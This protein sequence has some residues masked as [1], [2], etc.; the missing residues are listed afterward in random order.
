MSSQAQVQ[1]A[2]K[3][4]EPLLGWEC[5]ATVCF[6]SRRK[7][8]DGVPL[9]PSRLQRGLLG[10]E[11]A[12]GPCFGHHPHSEADGLCPHGACGPAPGSGPGTLLASALHGDALMQLRRGEVECGKEAVWLSWFRE[13]EKKAPDLVPRNLDIMV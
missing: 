3:G 11:S 12:P 4:A 1:V 8:V 13:Q 2:N 9:M 6:R 5:E 10:S 7:L